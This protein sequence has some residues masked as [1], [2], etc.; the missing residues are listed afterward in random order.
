M[1]KYKPF[2][3]N[4]EFLKPILNSNLLIE[5]IIAPEEYLDSILKKFNKIIKIIKKEK[6]LNQL[7][8]SL[9][10]HFFWCKIQF[11]SQDYTTKGMEDFI[12]FGIN[13]GRSLP[14]RYS[15]IGI[16]L[17]NNVLKI[18]SD[19]N[20]YDNFIKWLLFI[21]KHELVHRG[22]HLRIKDVE[23]RDEVYGKEFDSTKERL[24]TKSETMAIAW[25]AVELFKLQGFTKERIIKLISSTD[26]VKKR[27]CYTL[28][29][30]HIYFGTNSLELKLFYKYMYL[31]LDQE[32]K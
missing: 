7:C 16:F 5:N 18:Y 6:S 20:F 8:K 28:A 26:I 13:E 23:L 32:V 22:Q 3:I 24:A 2:F 12:K 9:S 14:D 30:Y 10:I 25:E 4:K 31:Y 19:K 11:I 1:K 27:L 29:A 17:N 21:L 15:T